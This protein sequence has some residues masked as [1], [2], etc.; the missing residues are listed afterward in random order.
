MPALTIS[1]RKLLNS[2]LAVSALAAMIRPARASVRFD[3]GLQMYTVRDPMAKA[4]LPTLKQIAALGYRN[5]ETFGFDAT[6]VGYYGMGA[7]EFKRTLDDLNLR[8]TSG[9]YDLSR[10]L[11]TPVPELRDYVSRCIEGAQALQQKYITWP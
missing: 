4:P 10:H 9:H 3:M 2:A 7:R 8:T 6:T 11:E 1:R 5:L